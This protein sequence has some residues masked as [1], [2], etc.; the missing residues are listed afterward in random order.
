MRKSFENNRGGD[1]FREK[2]GRG[3]IGRSEDDVGGDPFASVFL[4]GGGDG[5]ISTGPVGDQ[6]RDIFFAEG[7]LHFGSGKGDALVDLAGEA[8][9]RGEIDEY[10]PS[11]SQLAVNLYFRPGKSA[12]RMAGGVG[13][14]GCFEGES[15]DGASEENEPESRPMENGRRRVSSLSF[16]ILEKSRHQENETKQDQGSSIGSGKAESHPDQPE[17]GGEHGERENFFKG[18]HPSTWLRQERKEKREKRK[19]KDGQGETEGEGGEDE[20]SAE[21]RECESSSEG[22]AHERCSTG[23]GDRDGK[24]SGGKSPGP[25]MAGSFCGET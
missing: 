21:R 7:G 14:R 15:G 25:S 6:K 8:P 20:E 13:F 12:G 11:R 5:R 2:L 10:S 17:N 22:H 18:V 1:D 24:K 4:K 9:G 16:P 3:A 19:K 23:G